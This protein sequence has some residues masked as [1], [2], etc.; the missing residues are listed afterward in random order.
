[1]NKTSGESRTGCSLSFIWFFIFRNTV[2]WDQGAKAVNMSSSSYVAQKRA[3]YLRWMEN[4]HIGTAIK[5]KILTR[6][7]P[8]APSK[9]TIILWYQ[10]Y[11][12]RGRHSHRR[13]T[14]R[15]E[16]GEEKQKH[17]KV[18]LRD[19]L[20]HFLQ[21]FLAVAGVHH[22]TVWKVLDK[23][24]K[25]FPYCV[26]IGQQVSETS[27]KNQNVFLGDAKRKRRRILTSCNA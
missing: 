10:I 15:P 14:E 16:I 11:V 27:K 20:R 4:E 23:K 22:K 17:I 5:R 12:D 24:L 3:Q 1:M 8:P 6:Y 18:M 21:K 7:C 13:G 9:R 19:D 26:Q 25:V 2:Y